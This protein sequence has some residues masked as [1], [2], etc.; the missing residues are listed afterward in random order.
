MDVTAVEYC[1]NRPPE[2]SGYAKYI[3]G[4]LC[5]AANITQKQ[6]MH[7]AQSRES[8]PRFFIL[9]SERWQ[10]S[11]EEC[12]VRDFELPIAIQFAAA[13]IACQC[14]Y[15]HMQQFC[16]YGYV[17]RCERNPCCNPRS[18]RD[19]RFWPDPLADSFQMLP[20]L[21]DSPESLGDQGL[22]CY[23]THFTELSIA[24]SADENYL[25]CASE[26]AAQ[27]ISQFETLTAQLGSAR[28]P[29]R[30]F[31]LFSSLNLSSI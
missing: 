19:K 23:G 27:N 28:G 26:L 15:A 1:R 11:S 20:G 3:D 9:L 12:H 6:K 29:R 5:T 16:M 4:A 24:C 22:S 25:P 13:A 2:Q 8:W 30:R 21:P 18:L 17:K 14:M 10:S 7:M 31:G